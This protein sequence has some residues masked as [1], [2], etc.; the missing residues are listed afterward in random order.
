MKEL[1]NKAVVV[2]SDKT[3]IIQE[4]HIAVGHM[5]SLL[6]ERELFGGF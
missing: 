5:V 4:V 1:V 2:A 3:S 6:V